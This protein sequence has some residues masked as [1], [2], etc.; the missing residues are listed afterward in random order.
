MYHQVGKLLK[1]KKAFIPS[2]TMPT[3][4]ALT[5]PDIEVEIIDEHVDEINFDSGADLVGIT[6][7]T[8]SASRAYEIADLFR[9]RG[10]KVLLGG[11]H[12]TVLPDEAKE[13]ADAVIVGEAEDAWS[14]IIGDL[15]KNELK[16]FYRPTFPDLK[17]LVIPRIDL[18]NL[19]KYQRI[20]LSK[21]PTIPL[22]TSRGCPFSCDF[23]LVTSFY[24]CHQRTKPIENVIAE[25]KAIGAKYYF[26]CDVNI[27]ADQQRAKA[28]FT[29]LIPLKIKWAGQ[30]NVFAARHPEMLRLARRSGCY[31]AYLGI[32]SINEAS[33]RSVN[34]R[35]NKVSEYEEQLKIFHDSGIPIHGSFVFGLDE[36]D[37][38]TID[39]TVEFVDRNQ[40]DKVTY[41]FLFPIPGTAQYNRIKAEGRMVHDKYWLDKTHPLLDVHY[42]PKKISR[43]RL[44]E[45]FWEANDK[46]FSWGSIVRRLFIPPQP[47]ALTS[48]VSNIYYRKMNQKRELTFS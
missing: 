39:Q 35:I 40:I 20:P 38:A 17:R 27:G 46:T 22:E 29:A 42:Q 15:R 9:Q 7:H 10:T 14:E 24:G 33:L 23:C 6:C 34:K 19:D 13:H 47:Q 2:I 32:E 1:F 25:I 18:I 37:E 3:L 4:A 28:L 21:L 26:F 31:A 44:L 48:F 16:P 36:D 11:I 5:P 45:K 41:Y 12:P 30:F 43:E 8:F